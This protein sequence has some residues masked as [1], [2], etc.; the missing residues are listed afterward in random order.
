MTHR[1]YH[2]EN[3][4][5]NEKPI[6]NVCV[7]ISI[8]I[9]SCKCDGISAEEQVV[10]KSQAVVHSACAIRTAVLTSPLVCRAVANGAFSA[11]DSCRS[12]AAR[13]RPFSVLYCRY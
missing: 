9:V 5:G 4:W 2:F 1:P 10:T 12:Q 3:G 8:V 6:V 13:P 7:F 11:Y